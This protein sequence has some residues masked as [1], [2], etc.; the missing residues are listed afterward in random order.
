MSEYRYLDS[1]LPLEF[2]SFKPWNPTWDDKIIS[3]TF[4]AG[5]LMWPVYYS[6]TEEKYS[7]GKGMLSSK[8]VNYS[9]ARVFILC[10]DERGIWYFVFHRHE[11]LIGFVTTSHDV[12]INITSPENRNKENSRCLI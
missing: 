7:R 6:K 5:K 12:K 4:T 9:P 1:V 11:N 3:F 8:D 2:T 10:N